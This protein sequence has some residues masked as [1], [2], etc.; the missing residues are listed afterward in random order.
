M[1][2]YTE[3]FLTPSMTFVHRQVVA[4]PVSVQS[5]VLARM[6]SNPVLFPFEPVHVFP[7]TMPER[8]SNLVFRKIGIRH[9]SLGSASRRRVVSVMARHRVNVVHAHFGWSG[10]EVLPAARELGIPLVVTFHG[11]DA[12]ALLG[13]RGYLRQLRELFAY[14]TVLTVSDAMRARLLEHG[15]DPDHT[16]TMHIGVPLDIFR[17][18]ERQPMRNKL[19]NGEEVVFIQVANFVEKKGHETTLRAFASLR[20]RYPAARL[21]LIGS[22]PLKERTQQLSR[23][24]GLGESVRFVSHLSTPEVVER[25]NG[26]DCFLHHSVTA[27]DGDQEGI[28]TAIMEAMATGLPVVSTLHGGIPELVTAGGILVKERD[29]R[30]YGSALEAVLA[31]GGDLGRAGRRVVEESFSLSS[32]CA[33][34]ESLYRDASR[35]LQS[36][37]PLA[38][39]ITPEVTD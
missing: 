24:L 19:R 17:F 31:D 2:V 21:E 8:V 29:V 33:S 5:V 32:Q 34:L 14:A 37:A 6:R 23:E 15:A 4:M 7:R 1:A 9:A 3:N 12:S 11:I 13:D 25:L 39:S 30:G 38:A 35:R 27:D 10:I 18:H 16:E 26:A 22:G 28:P 36:E 20:V